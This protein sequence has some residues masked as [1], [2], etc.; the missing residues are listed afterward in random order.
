M[1][2]LGSLGTP[3]T[4]QTKSLKP[5]APAAFN[6]SVQDRC[7]VLRYCP[8]MCLVISEPHLVP[9]SASGPPVLCLPFSTPLQVFQMT[10]TLYLKH[11]RAQPELEPDVPSSGSPGFPSL[12]SYTPFLSPTQAPD[13]DPNVSHLLQEAFISPAPP[14]ACWSLVLILSC[15]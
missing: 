14:E 7:C 5:P 9:P 6:Y 3:A 1:C 12:L 8:L 11:P 4:S 2:S 10:P 13:S 15:G